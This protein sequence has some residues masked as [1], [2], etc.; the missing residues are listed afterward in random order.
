MNHAVFWLTP[1]P[2]WISQDEIPF[3]ALVMSHIAVSHLSRPIGESSKMVPTLMENWASGWR[4]L[5]C[6]TRRE[7]INPTSLEPQRGQIGSPSGQRCA[8]RKAMQLSG[9]VKY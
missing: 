4:V 2:R 6:Q 7:A 5:H 1:K 8:A 9:S 3:L